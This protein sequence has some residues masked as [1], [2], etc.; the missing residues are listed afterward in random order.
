MLIFV[1]ANSK[2]HG[3]G[4]SAF[5]LCPT[6][7]WKWSWKGN[8]K[9]FFSDV[10]SRAHLR[11]RKKQ[12]FLPQ[13]TVLLVVFVSSPIPLSAVYNTQ[14]INTQKT[15]KASDPDVKFL[16]IKYYS[17][18]A[19]PPLLKTLLKECGIFPRNNKF[20]WSLLPELLQTFCSYLEQCRKDCLMLT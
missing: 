17:R 3:Y 6:P 1:T 18:K 11:G 5:S 16:G 20:F 7:L 4:L 15:C 13:D 9:A 10:E 2:I 12:S 8:W 19:S 14:Q